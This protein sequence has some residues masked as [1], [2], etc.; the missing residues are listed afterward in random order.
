[1]SNNLRDFIIKNSN[2]EFN[3]TLK[4]KQSIENP[5]VVVHTRLSELRSGII[6]EYSYS[7]TATTSGGRRNYPNASGSSSSSINSYTITKTRT[8]ITRSRY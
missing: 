7:K 5:S 6:D 3:N 1:M 8:T 4:E 2:L